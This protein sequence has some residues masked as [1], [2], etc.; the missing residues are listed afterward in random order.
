MAGQRLGSRRWPW[1]IAGWLAWAFVAADGATAAWSLIAAQQWNWDH[2]GGV[3][4]PALGGG[5][6]SALGQLLVRRGVLPARAKVRRKLKAD[7]E[8]AEVIRSGTLPPNA[9]PREWRPR[10]QR[11]LRTLIGTLSAAAALCVI[12]ALLTLIAAHLTSHDDPALGALAA[13]AL[14]LTAAPILL[15]S[16]ARRRGQL[17]LAQL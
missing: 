4:G 6:G 13:V 14:L 7:Q 8:T 3:V 16:W 2:F 10:V 9:D 17:L 5:L 1:I 12:S 15:A 11:H